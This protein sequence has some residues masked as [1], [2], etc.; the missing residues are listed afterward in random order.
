M[1]TG[2]Y[3]GL[4]QTTGIKN[5]KNDLSRYIRAAEAGEI[6]QVTDRG[7]VIAEISPPRAPLGQ[8]EPERQWALL[9]AKGLVTPAKIRQ[10][11][12]MPP[13]EPIMSFEE[14]MR[15]LDESRADR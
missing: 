5:L 6:V 2:N 15:D 7:R 11:T 13:T 14:L 12:P 9:I 8:T 1:A 10:G 3:F 4:M